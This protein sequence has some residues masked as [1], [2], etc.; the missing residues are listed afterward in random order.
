MND[1]SKSVN[2]YSKEDIIDIKKYVK[3][4]TT[5]HDINSIKALITLFNTFLL[6]CFSLILMKYSIIGIPAISFVTIRTFIIFH[7]CCHRSFFKKISHNYYLAN[8]LSPFVLQSEENWRSG[9]NHHHQTH[10]NRNLIDHTKTVISLQEF[11]ES[12][13]TYKAFYL[14]IRTPPVFFIVIPFYAFF[15][16]NL[17]KIRYMIQYSTLLGFLFYI[18]GVDFMYRFILGQYISTI[19]G[20]MLF[21][22]QHQVNIGYWEFFDKTDTLSK[23]NSELMGS[24]MIQIPNYLKWITLG[25]EYH[26]IH[27]LNPRVPCYNLKDCHDNCE[28]RFD[29]ITSINFQDCFKALFHTFYDSK[30]KKYISFK[31]FSIFGLEQVHKSHSKL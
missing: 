17:N 25:I 29:K 3:K 19:I 13:F 23:D 28:G 15:I 6:Y 4:Y 24:S 14:F 8:I 1:V 18:G 12:P 20:T 22:L 5:Y 10:G 2:I 16:S 9:H 21:H 26:H 27:H 31:I 30:N 7:D 11:N